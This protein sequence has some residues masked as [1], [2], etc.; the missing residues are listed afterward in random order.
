MSANPH[1]HAPPRPDAR[2]SAGPCAHFVRG[3]C[4]LAHRWRRGGLCAVHPSG[5]GGPHPVAARSDVAIRVWAALSA[6]AAGHARGHSSYA[7]ARGRCVVGDG[8]RLALCLAGHGD[9]RGVGR[10]VRAG[11]HRDQT[12][13]HPGRGQQSALLADPPCR[14]PRFKCHPQPLAGGVLAIIATSARPSGPR[15]SALAGRIVPITGSASGHLGGT[16]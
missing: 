16:L 8:G 1:I 5:H 7:A 12:A 10:A 6:G 3:V 2:L 4:R 11:F 13:C 14:H 15:R 9:R